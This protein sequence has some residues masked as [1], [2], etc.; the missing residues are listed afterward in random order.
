[1]G[2]RNGRRFRETNYGDS[3]TTDAAISGGVSDIYGNPIRTS[4]FRRGRTGA[5]VTAI[6]NR[7]SDRDQQ[8]KSINAISTV[9]L[10]N[11]D[12]HDIDIL[13]TTGS[14]TLFSQSYSDLARI[15]KVDRST[16]KRRFD[17]VYKLLRVKM[18]AAS[19]PYQND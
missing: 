12:Q 4:V 3:I 2:T 17:K 11:F 1:M 7:A 8:R 5:P 6:R 19:E 13:L 16:I 18:A 9:L 15:L 10:E 14:S